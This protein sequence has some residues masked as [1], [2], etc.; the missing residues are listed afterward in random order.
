[1]IVGLPLGTS[2]SPTD[3]LRSAAVGAQLARITPIAGIGF[4]LLT[5]LSELLKGDSPSTVDPPLR[6]ATYLE[7]HR[8]GI[9]GGAYV[10][11]LGL[12]LFLIVVLVAIERIWLVGGRRV[13]AAFAATGALLTIVAYTAYVF[14]TSALAFGAGPDLDLGTLESLWEVRFVAETFIAFP[15]ALLLG[16]V[17]VAGLRMPGLQTWYAP[18][19]I[20]AAFAFLVGAAAVARTGFFAPDGDYG[21]ILFWLLPLWV[22]V[23]AFVATPRPAS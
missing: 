19:T 9:L 1:V 20:F 21:F 7:E 12:A 23:T 18:A 5:L 6:V 22:A 8:N 11:M 10:Q 4:L 13:E 16:A 15:A 14:F 3:G 2:R 17:G